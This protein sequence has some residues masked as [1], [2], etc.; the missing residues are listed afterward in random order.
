MIGEITT[1]LR[2]A[3]GW[4][5]PGNRAADAVLL[6]DSLEAQ[7]RTLQAQKEALHATIL[8]QGANIARCRAAAVSARELLR[9]I[10]S[11]LDQTAKRSGNAEKW[12]SREMRAVTLDKIIALHGRFGQRKDISNG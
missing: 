9:D 2:K 5:L 8:E 4:S 11:D 1:W 10:W 7:V 12:N 3:A 6:V